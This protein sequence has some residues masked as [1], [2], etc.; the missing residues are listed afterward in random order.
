MAQSVEIVEDAPTSNNGGAQQPEKAVRRASL[1]AAPLSS[2]TGQQQQLKKGAVRRA[3]LAVGA[4]SEKLIAAFMPKRR[5]GSFSDV[6]TMDDSDS[7][8]DNNTRNSNASKAAASALSVDNLKSFLSP[9]LLEQMQQRERWKK[10]TISVST[11]D[12]DIIH[13]NQQAKQSALSKLVSPTVMQALQARQKSFRAARDG[14]DN[15]DDAKNGIG[16]SH[17]ADDESDG[18]KP[19]RVSSHELQDSSRS[20]SCQ[21]FSDTKNNGGENY[22]NDED[23]QQCRLKLQQEEEGPRAPKRKDPKKEKEATRKQTNNNA[24]VAKKKQGN[25]LTRSRSRSS[26]L[27]PNQQ[28]RRSRKMQQ[29]HQRQVTR[30]S[31]NSKGRVSCKNM[32]MSSDHLPNN[33]EHNNRRRPMPRRAKSGDMSNAI[34]HSRRVGENTR[35]RRTKSSV[36]PAAMSLSRSSTAPGPIATRRQ[37]RPGLQPSGKSRR[38][39]RIQRNLGSNIFQAQ[40]MQAF[41]RGEDSE[42]ELESEQVDTKLDPEYHNDDNDDDASVSS[43]SSSSSLEDS[44][45][46]NSKKKKKGAFK[47]AKRAFKKKQQ[48]QKSPCLDESF[49]EDDDNINS[50]TNMPEHVNILIEIVR[51]RNILIGD[52]T[53]SDPYV[54]AKLGG[55]QIH[56]TSKIMK[57]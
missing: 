24:E 42:S 36:G 45:K 37:S 3:S 15:D 57:T 48:H 4:S 30:Q 25:S 5:V 28:P 18:D 1:A 51:A 16:I 26:S 52:T 39:S 54:L 2:L 20:S 27:D 34:E 22:E 31:S 50:D 7:S 53:T 46:S 35:L 13:K 8:H 11:H 44:H 32:N 29:E 55:R 9:A 56:K 21:D 41:E 47:K 38:S 40:L 12:S 23:L 43:S 49:V 33:S 6:L 14:N 17:D 19:L 10:K